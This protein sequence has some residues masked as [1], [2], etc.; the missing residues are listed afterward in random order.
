MATRHRFHGLLQIGIDI[1]VIQY[2]FGVHADVVVDDELQARQA[3]AIIR[4]L[5]EVKRQL[6]ITHV[7]HDLGFDLRHGSALNFG[8]LG[9]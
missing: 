9:L 3:H 6:R 7:H 4:Q 1:R 8:H 5:A 2:R